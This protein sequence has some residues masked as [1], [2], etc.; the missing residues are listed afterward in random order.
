MDMNLLWAM[1][2]TLAPVVLTVLF[3]RRYNFF[4]GLIS[5]FV[6]SYLVLFFVSAFQTKLPAEIVA[7]LVG[8]GG[9]FGLLTFYS[10]LYSLLGTGLSKL[11]L[12]SLVE[13]N[14]WKYIA[15]AIY[16]VI[17]VVSQIIASVI[18]SHR[19]N[20][21]KNLKRQVKRY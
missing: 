2:I 19:V 14:Y 12:S 13:A 11:G 8:T 7:Y 3:S 9:S 18:R 6:F 17:F 15:L 21:I 4:H 1:L 10:S 16:V 20:N 5:F